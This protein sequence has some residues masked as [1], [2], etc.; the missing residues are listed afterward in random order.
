MALNAMR[1]VLCD[2][3]VV[4]LL[5]AARRLAHRDLRVCAEQIC[6]RGAHHLLPLEIRKFEL[7]IMDLDRSNVDRKRSPSPFE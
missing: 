5:F 2:G 1:L 3:S 6:P 7:R 4:N